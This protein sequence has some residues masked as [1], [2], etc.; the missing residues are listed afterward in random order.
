MGSAPSVFFHLRNSFCRHCSTSSISVHLSYSG[1]SVPVF[2]SL[3]LCCRKV[4]HL[5]TAYQHSIF[6]PILFCFMSPFHLWFLLSLGVAFLCCNKCEA[7]PCWP[8][9][10]IFWSVK[11][12]FLYFL[13]P[14]TRLLYIYFLFT[15]K[16][17][18][19]STPYRCAS[20]FCGH[21]FP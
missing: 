20:F 16:S 1:G 15:R 9:P 4:F 2:H 11:L 17:G 6:P 10:L 13:T 18:G 7:V 19:V 5:A 3:T 12:S 14:C 21:I 8:I